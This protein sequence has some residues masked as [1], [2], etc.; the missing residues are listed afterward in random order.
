M[1]DIIRKFLSKDDLTNAEATKT[2]R[3]MVLGIVN[4]YMQ[5]EV[6]I[7]EINAIVNY[8]VN[9]QNEFQV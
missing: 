1:L 7:Q 2:V 4:Y 6:S 8:V 3:T 5:K 9:C